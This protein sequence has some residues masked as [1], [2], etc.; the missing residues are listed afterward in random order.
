MWVVIDGLAGSGKTWFAT[1]LARKEWRGGAEVWGNYNLKFN[2]ENKDVHRFYV[3]DE[4]YHLNKAVIVLDEAQ[5]LAGHWLAMPEVF[6]NKIAHHRHH[7]LDV[8]S[9]TQDFQNIHVYLRRN[10]H[11]RYRVSSLM[12]FPRKDR[13][14]PLLQIIRVAKKTRK[15]SIENDDNLIWKQE[16]RAKLFFISRLWTREYYDTFANID[17]D[18]YICKLEY[19]KK[20]KEKRGIWILKIENR[21]MKHL[22]K[23]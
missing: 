8:I 7:H 2:L 20:P 14:K 16:G 22:R 19:E 11:E 23:S 9:T 5:D 12:R 15:I 4:I 13:V 3:L 10:V 6:R 18:K 1:R 21:D 17:F